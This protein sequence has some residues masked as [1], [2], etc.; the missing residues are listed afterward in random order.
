MSHALKLHPAKQDR[1]KQV[2]M[3]TLEKGEFIK[4]LTKPPMGADRVTYTNADGAKKGFWP[5]YE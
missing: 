5:L 4:K 3:E 1:Q 2:Q